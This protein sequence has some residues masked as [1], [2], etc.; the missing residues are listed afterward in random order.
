MEFYRRTILIICSFFLFIVG[1]NEA[2]A[3]HHEVEEMRRQA[4]EQAIQQAQEK[5]RE[6]IDNEVERL[7]RALDLEYWQVFYADSVMTHDFNAMQEELMKLQDFKVSNT[8][9]YSICQDKWAEKIY[10]AFKKFLTPAQWKKYNKIGAKR[11]KKA[12]DKRKAKR[13]K[14][15]EEINK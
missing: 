14:S 5:L 9:M 15:T 4:K 10:V 11:D 2:M 7:N 1:A 3:Q 6:Y 8:D 12:R 13:K